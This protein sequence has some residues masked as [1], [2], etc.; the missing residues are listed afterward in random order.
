MMVLAMAPARFPSLYL[1]LKS[2]SSGKGFCNGSEV[3]C[4]TALATD[5]YCDGS[6]VESEMA[7]A[8]AL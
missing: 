5:P 7:L 2:V 4:A 1:V 6:I 3:E 8:T